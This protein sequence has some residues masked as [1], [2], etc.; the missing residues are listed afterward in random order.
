MEN[1]D[2]IVLAF[3][4]QKNIIHSVFW[5]IPSKAKLFSICEL[6]Y[7]LRAS[8]VLFFL[9]YLEIYA[10]NTSFQ[11]PDTWLCCQYNIKMNK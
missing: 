1:A 6:Y 8:S 3:S 2:E 10:C 4:F 7:R 9:P 11:L 5:K